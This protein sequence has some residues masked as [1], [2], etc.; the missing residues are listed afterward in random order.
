MQHDPVFNWGWGLEGHHQGGVVDRF[1]TQGIAGSDAAVVG[2][3]KE[4][5]LALHTEVEVWI[6]DE[7]GGEYPVVCG[8]R[9]AV[10]E[11]CVRIQMEGGCHAVLGG[12]PGLG[13]SW[14]D[15]FRSL[16]DVGQAVIQLIQNQVLEGGAAGGAVRIQAIPGS[17][18]AVVDD[19]I[20][21]IG[22]L[23]CLG[24]A[25]LL[26]GSAFLGAGAFLGA[27]GGS[28]AGGGAAGVAA[29]AA[30][31]KCHRHCQRDG[32]AQYTQHMFFHEFTS[33]FCLFHL[34]VECVAHTLTDKIKANDD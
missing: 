4:F 23:C 32:H 3:F 26:G 9:G 21:V 13:G 19:N 12:F 10:V 24:I 8:D 15:R 16:G 30:Q 7:V 29:A 5:E 34:R 25:G 18:E 22:G 11:F 20:R 6:G 2:A 27:R 17:G 28:F 33:P 31:C 1:D 14:L